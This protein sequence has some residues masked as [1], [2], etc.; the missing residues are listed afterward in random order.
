MKF[1]GI[2]KHFSK[3]SDKKHS[4][5]KL[6]IIGGFKLNPG[7]VKQPIKSVIFCA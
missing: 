6:V 2:G 1:Y 5:A 3:N 7:L 4:Y